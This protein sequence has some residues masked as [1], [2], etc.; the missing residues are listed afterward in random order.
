MLHLYRILLAVVSGTVVLAG[1]VFGQEWV[2]YSHGDQ[3]CWVRSPNALMISRSGVPGQESA[4]VIVSV[5]KATFGN[6]DLTDHTKV[7]MVPV[8]LEIDGVPQGEIQA[9]IRDGGDNID[10]PI[11]VHI[12]ALAGELLQKLA[13]GGRLTVAFAGEQG[14]P[15]TSFA[16]SLAGSSAAIG[17]LSECASG[18][19]AVPVASAPPVC[20]TLNS[21]YYTESERGRRIVYF[22]DEEDS[23]SWRRDV[24]F[25]LWK[26]DALVARMYGNMVSSM[27]ASTTY[28][29]VL[30]K[31]Y[32]LHL[33]PE[34]IALEKDPKIATAI[35]EEVYEEDSEAAAYLVLAGLNQLLWNRGSDHVDFYGSVEDKDR[36]MAGPNVLY[37]LACRKEA[38]DLDPPPKLVFR[39]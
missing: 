1:S 35:V 9:R 16:Y 24:F 32:P 19:E 31:Y 27:G 26:N 4:N 38:V 23:S 33:D 13:A 28:V 11:D 8:D 37:H 25:E 2:Q 20:N 36:A 22:G 12:D 6:P 29:T 17:W 18:E 21:I 7:V 5:P 30:S 10:S 34:G 39:P 15:S 14:R 3:L